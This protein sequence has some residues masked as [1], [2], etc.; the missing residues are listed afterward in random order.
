MTAKDRPL[1]RG[2]SFLGAAGGHVTIT[3]IVRTRA[4]RR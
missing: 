3:A 4:S 1:D 2:D